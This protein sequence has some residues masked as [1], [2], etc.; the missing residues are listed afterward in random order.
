MKWLSLPPSVTRFLSVC[1][2]TYNTWETSLAIFNHLAA[3][4]A[5]SP[6]SENAFIKTLLSGRIRAFK[7]VLRLIGLGETVL[8]KS[9]LIDQKILFVTMWT[10]WTSMKEFFLTNAASFE[11]HNQALV[12]PNPTEWAL[13]SNLVSD[14]STATKNFVESQAIVDASHSF[15]L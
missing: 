9:F 4:T 3:N 12:S 1:S 8:R 14:S 13:L 15:T 5:C 11:I 10:K 2:V 7:D 6:N